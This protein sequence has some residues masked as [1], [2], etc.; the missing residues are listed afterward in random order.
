M[1]VSIIIPAYNAESFLA[2]AIYSAL[3]QDY[4][5]TEIIIVDN[6]ST[7]GTAEIIRRFV[8]DYPAKIIATNAVRQGCS[9]ARNTGL[10]MAS[11][12]W[13]A[14]LD[15]DDQ[16]D[17]TRI[18]HQIKQIK[19]DTRWVISAYRHHYP[20]GSTEDSIPN[21]DPWCGLVHNF[22]I[23][24]TS[25]NLIHRE[26]L[27]KIGG[28]NEALPDNTDPD[29]HF[30]LLKNATP[31]VLDPV[32]LTHYRHHD[33]E[34]VTTRKP[35]ARLIRKADFHWSVN[36]YLSSERPAY[37]TDHARFFHS[38]ELA[39]LRMLA[40][41]DINAAAKRYARSFPD[42]RPPVDVNIA[43]KVT[44]L[45]PYLGFRQTERLRNFVSCCLPTEWLHQFKV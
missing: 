31:Y 43:T 14:F 30:R 33:A 32:I 11:G 16:I 6:N 29:L 9:Q 13:I 39:A 37:W 15:A 12:E 35:V 45:Y 20:D 17:T 24:Y 1:K 4:P 7:D 38:C 10:A 8:R 21:P 19:E 36:Q 2:R 44:L 27:E 42:G 34:R 3:Q 41:Y 22:E 5:D 26:A 18:S 28:W 23:G 40:T 25:A